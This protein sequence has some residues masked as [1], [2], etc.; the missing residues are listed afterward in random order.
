MKITKVK[1]FNF[2]ILEN[3]TVD[4]DEVVTLIVGRNNSGKTSLAEVFN[5]FFSGEKSKFR[6]EDFTLN[7]Y[8]SFVESKKFYDEYKLSVENEEAEEVILEKETRYKE[9]FPKIVVEIYLEYEDED[10]GKLSSISNFLMDL[11][12]MRKDALISC[13]YGV[14]EMEKLFKFYYANAAEY[15]N[16]FIAFLKKNLHYFEK[17]FFSVDRDNPKYRSHIEKP[18]EIENIFLPRFIHAQTNLDDKSDDN[19]KGLSK[20]FESYFKLN[21]EN[22]ATAKALKKSLDDTSNEMDV[23]YKEFFKTIFA[24]LKDFGVNSGINI[25][26]IEVKSHFEVEEVLKDNA[27]LFYK[28]DGDELLPEKSNGLGYSKLI[29]IVLTILSYYEE[30]SK[31]K[32]LPNFSLLFIEEPEAHLHPQMQQT[33]IKNINE[34]V[35]KKKWNAQIVITTHSSHIVA[36]SGFD[37]I[38]YFDNSTKSVEVKNLTLFKDKLA[39]SSPETLKFLKQYMTL[40]NCDMFFADKI[41]MVEGT[42][43]RLLLPEMIRMAAPNLLSQYISIIEVGGAYALNF[44]E[45]LEF[46]NVKTLLITDLDSV[47]PE[48]RGT[49][50]VQIA[51]QVADGLTTSNATLKKWIPKKIKPSELLLCTEA[52]KLNDTSRIRIAYQIPE[53]AGEKCGRSFEEAFIIKN[54]AMFSTN[55]KNIS[56]RKIF[57]EKTKVG[58]KTTI[59]NKSTANIVLQ[60]YEIAEEIPK[61]TEFAFDIMILAGWAVPKYIKEGLTWLEK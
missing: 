9:A 25:Q 53:T 4:F 52:E 43:E 47:K 34:F 8:K 54:A 10:D 22:D 59:S 7:S 3:V 12:E 16:N 39:T 19:T 33:F 38:R 45:F 20:G 42:V 51:C 46:I 61:K 11:D 29:F 28:H 1:I 57:L 14:F 17:R 48:K 36:D 26:E 40:Y 27:N 24:D 30:Q 5:N 50:T 2:R 35:K 21:K 55:T 37:S 13:E 60:S 44:K 31:R 58:N 49:K 6:F 23:N 41:I 56:S 32:T 15:E 18:S